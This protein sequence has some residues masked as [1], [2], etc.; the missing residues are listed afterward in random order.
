ME[1]CRRLLIALH[2]FFVFTTLLLETCGKNQERAARAVCGR[3]ASGRAVRAPA[4]WRGIVV[5]LGKLTA[6]RTGRRATSV[7]HPCYVSKLRR[8]GPEV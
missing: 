2:V 5:I 8:L 4:R 6:A 7:R 1:L 3:A